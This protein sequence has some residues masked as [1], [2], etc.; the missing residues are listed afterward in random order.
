MATFSPPALAAPGVRCSPSSE[1]PNASTIP[2]RG[3]NELAPM[4]CRVISGENR[5]FFTLRIGQEAAEVKLAIASKSEPRMG[6][7]LAM[8]SYSSTCSVRQDTAFHRKFPTG[9]E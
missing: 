5:Q 2:H 9:R 1:N 4:K 8:Y 3:A 7:V 6:P